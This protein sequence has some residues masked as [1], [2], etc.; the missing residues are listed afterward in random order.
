MGE[1]VHALVGM[2]GLVSLAWLMSEERRAVPWRAVATGLGLQIVLAALL[3][4]V[5]FL[6]KAFLLLN[7]ALLVLEKATQAGTSLVFGYL[8]GGYLPF[9]VT[10]ANSTFIL[11]FRALPL[12]LVISAL[13]A[14]L[15]YWRVLPLIV[16]M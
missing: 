12:V 11:A 13:T 9:Q 10:D 3:L 7:D 2:A 15:F 16:R 6:N 8:G 4:K 1:F 5:E 14:L